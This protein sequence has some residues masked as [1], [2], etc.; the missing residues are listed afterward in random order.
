MGRV[1]SPLPLGYCAGRS[2]TCRVGGF[3]DGQGL[4]FGHCPISVAWEPTATPIGFPRHVL[5]WV[6][7]EAAGASMLAEARSK[8]DAKGMSTWEALGT[9]AQMSREGDP[10]DPGE[11]P[12]R[13]WLPGFRGSSAALIFKS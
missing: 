5:E 4:L 7:K 13:C 2:T 6:F 12:R 9:I 3:G 1:Y 10:R 8:L 11:R